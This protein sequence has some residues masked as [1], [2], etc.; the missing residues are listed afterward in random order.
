M[1]W[2]RGVTGFDLV[3]D[4]PTVLLCW[5][6][7]IGAE[8]VEHLSDEMVAEHCRTLLTWFTG[9]DVP[10]PTEIVRQAL[11]LVVHYPKLIKN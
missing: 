6:G 2:T 1:V 11:N 4:L 3:A 9:T 8:L 5:V 10:L 7:G